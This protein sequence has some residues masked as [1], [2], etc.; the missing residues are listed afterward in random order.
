M[1]QNCMNIFEPSDLWSRKG[2]KLAID[3]MPGP[4]NTMRQEDELTPPWGVTG[5]WSSKLLC[6]ELSEALAGAKTPRE[7]T[8]IAPLVQTASIATQIKERMSRVSVSVG[9]SSALKQHP[10]PQSG[11]AYPPPPGLVAG[12]NS[13]KTGSREPFPCQTVVPISIGTHGHPNSCSEACKY[14]KRKGGCREGENCPKCHL[15]HWQRPTLRARAAVAEGGPPATHTVTENIQEAENNSADVFHWQPAK[16][17][18]SSRTAEEGNGASG[19]DSNTV[20]SGKREP[21]GANGYWALLVDS[22]VPAPKGSAFPPAEEDANLCMPALSIGSIGHPHSCAAACRYHGKMGGCKD[23]NQCDR[24]H[25]CKWSRYSEKTAT[26]TMNMSKN[27]NDNVPETP[28]IGGSSQR[29]IQQNVDNESVDVSLLPLKVVLP[30]SKLVDESAKQSV[31]SLAPSMG[32]LGHPFNCCS[33]CKYHRRSGGCRDGR[34]CMKCH[35]CQ[36]SRVHCR[37]T[38]QEEKPESV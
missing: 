28:L 29:P 5:V 1:S 32:S 8:G 36:W 6:D 12:L 15:C 21:S 4:Y 10:T 22:Y 31:V 23:G 19:G 18:N 7:S 26:F 27:L 35:L 14:V 37:T 11:D 16:G 38:T 20:F 13:F 24:C 9:A 34:Q 33:P 30:K 2:S 25:L 3:T 17:Q